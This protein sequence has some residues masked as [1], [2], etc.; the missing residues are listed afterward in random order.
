MR[1]LCLVLPGLQTAVFN[2]CSAIQPPAFSLGYI[3]QRLSLIQPPTNL[4]TPTNGHNQYWMVVK[5]EARSR[6]IV[7]PPVIAL[8]LTSRVSQPA[9]FF[10]G[11]RTRL[12]LLGVSKLASGT[13]T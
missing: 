5:T 1:S 2:F 7:N 10:S 12:N 6:R 4:Y 3:R 8:S 9:A 11:H 13:A